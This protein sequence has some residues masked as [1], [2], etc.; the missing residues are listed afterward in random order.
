MEYTTVHF[1]TPE[2]DL[3]KIPAPDFVE[4]PL[5]G[6]SGLLKVIGE[7]H[8]KVHQGDVAHIFQCKTNLNHRFFVPQNAEPS[9]YNQMK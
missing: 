6:C 8:Q 7:V 3:I 9:R 5:Q 4:C 1:R 2:G